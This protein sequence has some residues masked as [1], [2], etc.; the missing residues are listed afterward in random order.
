MR[1]GRRSVV[2]GLLGVVLSAGL[3]TLLALP[4]VALIGSASVSDVVQGVG[5]PMFV[6]AL[7]FHI[8]PHICQKYF[9]RCRGFVLGL[10]VKI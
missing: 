5:S 4:F 2:W 10:S 1:V 3:M 8:Y 9:I 7:G 6:P